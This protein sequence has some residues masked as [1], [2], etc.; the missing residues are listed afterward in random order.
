M[1]QI[2]LTN[3]I[4]VHALVDD[5]DYDKLTCHPWRLCDTGRHHCAIRAQW[6]NKKVKMII[7]AREIMDCPMG[8]MVDHKNHNQLDNRRS[9][10]RICT[11]QQNQANSFSQKGGTSKY[12]GVSYNT[13]RN[14]WVSVICCNG[15]VT[16]LGSFEKEEDAARA[17]D[18]K[19]LEVFG[20]YAHLN[21]QSN[22]LALE[23]C[24]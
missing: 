8:M 11:N 14:H 17:Y 2:K 13:R 5:S 21:L 9:N 18:K 3:T 6:K 10:L 15:K 24:G 19:A 20:E 4:D 12:K 23:S 7:M 22:G 1:K 16:Y